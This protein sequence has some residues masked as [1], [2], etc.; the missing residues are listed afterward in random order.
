MPIADTPDVTILAPHWRR[1]SAQVTDLLV[2]AALSVGGLYLVA[3]FHIDTEATNYAVIC[4]ALLIY[5]VLLPFVTRGSSVGR[6]LFR[7]RIARESDASIP[8]LIQYLARLFT[9]IALYAI[10]A[11][12]VT[13][14]I[15]LPMLCIVCFVEGLTVL[16]TRRRQSLG[17]LVA[18]TTV[19][20]PTH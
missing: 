18:R 15:N 13:F 16:F 12:F 10:F 5:Y 9:R 14:E 6:A 8:T 2:L 11:I 4:G 20:A 3:R 19:L 17:D 1:A 7:L